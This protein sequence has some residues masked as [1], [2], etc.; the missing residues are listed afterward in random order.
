MRGIH[1]RPT[2]S[3]FATSDKIR[4]IVNHRAKSPPSVDVRAVRARR[5]GIAMPDGII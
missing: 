3:W 1:P 5:V 4:P 2:R